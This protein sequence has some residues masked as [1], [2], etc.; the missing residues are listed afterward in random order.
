MRFADHKLCKKDVSDCKRVFVVFL[1]ATVE[2]PQKHARIQTYRFCTVYGQ[3]IPFSLYFAKYGSYRLLNTI[4]EKTKISNYNTFLAP[5][6]QFLDHFST[7]LN[8][9]MTRVPLFHTFVFT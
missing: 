9:H 1:V 2:K 8:S 4:S 7:R 6:T 3:Q 5:K